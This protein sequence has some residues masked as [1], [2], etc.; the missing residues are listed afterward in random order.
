MREYVLFVDLDT[1]MIAASKSAKELGLGITR[2][3][4]LTFT[5]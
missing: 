4:N 2:C 1:R 5:T 3:M